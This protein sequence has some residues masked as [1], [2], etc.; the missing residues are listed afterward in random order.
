MLL[1]VGRIHV[2]AGYRRTRTIE[3]QLR[4]NAHAGNAICIP[5]FFT[6]RRKTFQVYC[7]RTA[8]QKRPCILESGTNNLWHRHKSSANTSMRILTYNTRGSLGMDGQ[9]STR[10]IAQTVRQ[11]S[12]D[13]VCFQEIHQRMPQSGG[14]DQPG[15]LSRY[16]GRIFIFQRN[17]RIGVGRYGIGIATRATIVSIKEHMLPSVR[18]QRGALEL[19]LRDVAGIGGV[20]VF[21]THWGLDSEEREKQAAFLVPL[22]HEAKGPVVFCG[23]LNEGPDAAGIKALLAGTNL[24]DADT[25]Q[26]R[27][28]FI[29]DDPKERIDYILYSPTLAA[30]YVEVV[31]SQAS[32]HLPLLADLTRI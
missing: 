31:N 5:G 24:V 28:T 7:L 20:T 26:N 4:R 3:Q 13:I 1:S 30:R 12:P 32:D 27:P 23:D 21:C 18:E 14:E 6:F 22:I 29:A 2:D 9:R 17:L 10:R 15:M 16:L 11:L 25:P 8:L 19:R